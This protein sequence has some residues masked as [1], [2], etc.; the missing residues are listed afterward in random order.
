MTQPIRVRIIERVEDIPQDAAFA[1]TPVSV[2]GALMSTL[3]DIASFQPQQPQPH[4]YAR[5]EDYR[6][7]AATWEIS[8]MAR[9][10]L[11]FFRLAIE[12]AEAPGDEEDEPPTKRMEAVQE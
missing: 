6:V 8:E 5:A 11:Q 9:K 2:L 4:D 10:T 7:A 3:M 12:E 1:V